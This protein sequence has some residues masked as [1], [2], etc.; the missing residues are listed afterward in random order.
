MFLLD[1]CAL[2]WWSL[3][4]NKLSDKAAQACEKM[5]KTGGFISS[6]SLWEIGIKIKKGKLDIG[7]SLENFVSGIKKTGIIK[8][9]PVD[10]AIWME[11]LA[12]RWK[13]PDPADR[14]IVATAK[15]LK[16]PL[17]TADKSIK[18]FY[19]KVIW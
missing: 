16:L 17:V 2:V 12:L 3:D 14:T 13:H 4:P 15:L 10:E 18:A 8:I 9:I 5:E 19:K 11:N 6:I 7:L 1:T